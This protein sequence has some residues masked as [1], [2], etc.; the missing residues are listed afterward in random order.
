MPPDE[1]RQDALRRF[2]DFERIRRACRRIRVGERIMLQQI[3]IL[4]TVVLLGAVIFL[5]MAHYSAQRA[6]QAAVA[7]MT[8]ALEKIAAAS[9]ERSSLAEAELT[10]K[11]AAAPPVVVDTS[12]KSGATDVD[13]ELKEIRVTFSKPMM[14]ES[15]SW[16]QASDETYPE[17][18][19]EPRYLA[20]GKTCVLP[21]NLAPSKSYEIWLNSEKFHNFKDRDGRPAVPHYLRFQT[22]K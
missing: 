1:A 4:L 20:D 22:K 17:T 14:D 6:Q 15:W 5:C 3:Q 18:T 7:Q 2:G 11:L 12:P 9:R 16:S 19:G 21:V 13:P 8:E 10:A